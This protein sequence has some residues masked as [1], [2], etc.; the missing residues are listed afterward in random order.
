MEYPM[1]RFICRWCPIEHCDFFH[2]FPLLFVEKS[3]SFC[4]VRMLATEI[5]V[6][7]FHEKLLPSG[8]GNGWTS[9]TKVLRPYQ[10]HQCPM[11]SPRKWRD[12]RTVLVSFKGWSYNMIWI[13]IYIYM[14]YMIYPSVNGIH[15]YSYIEND[16][17]SRWFTVPIRSYKKLGCSMIFTRGYI[18]DAEMF[19]NWSDC[20]NPTLCRPWAPTL[21]RPGWGRPSATGPCS[22]EQDWLVAWINVFAL[23]CYRFIHV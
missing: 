3:M 2:D 21:R 13:C 8:T 1:K 6:K 23:F 9:F 17:F 10:V 19:P 5:E 14:I 20:W 11:I 7:C 16:H 15:Y 22:E 12:G 18:G 4:K